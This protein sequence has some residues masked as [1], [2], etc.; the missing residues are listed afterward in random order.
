MIAFIGSFNIGNLLGATAAGLFALWI[1]DRLAFFDRRAYLT[2]SQPGVVAARD[3]AHVS[4]CS[5]ERAG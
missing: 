1:L 5:A 3:S 4:C 2:R